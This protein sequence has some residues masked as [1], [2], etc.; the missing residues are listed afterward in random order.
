MA[1]LSYDIVPRNGGWAI[2]MTPAPDENFATRQTAFDAAA[3]LARK[4]R[5]TGTTISVRT[6]KQPRP[7]AAKAG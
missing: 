5:F 3:E 4:L 2:L 6:E 7:A 1:H